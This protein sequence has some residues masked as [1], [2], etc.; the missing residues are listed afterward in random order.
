MAFR[1]TLTPTF[2]APVKVLT[3]NDKGGFDT[4]TFDA[5]FS[6]SDLAENEELKN[7]TN[8]DLVKRKCVGWKLVDAETNESVLWSPEELEAVLMVPGAALAMA[9]AFWSSLVG[10]REKN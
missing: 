3:P 6:R 9:T 1:R 2:L 7:L 8:V 4:N 10:V 5:Q